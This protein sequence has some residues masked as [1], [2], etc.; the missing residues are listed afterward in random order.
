LRVFERENIK[1][2][3]YSCGFQEF[4]RFDYIGLPIKIIMIIFNFFKII[5]AG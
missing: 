1:K 4:Y 5:K 2:N 3:Q